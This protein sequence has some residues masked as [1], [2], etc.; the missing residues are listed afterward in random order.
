[1]QQTLLL[2]SFINLHP[3]SVLLLDEPDAHLE[4]LRQRQIY[5]LLREAATQNETQVICASHSEVIL[6]EAAQRDA[7]VAFVGKPHRVEDK[8]QVLKAL[9][10]IGF[11]DY[12]QAEITGFVLYLEGATDLALLRAFAR[13]LE[14]DAMEV[15]ER[16]FIKYVGN[17]I[18][19]ARTHFH[20]LREAKEDLL[21]YA[22]FDR[23][24]RD[25]LGTRRG[26]TEHMWP[27]R[28]IENYL[29]PPKTLPRFAKREGRASVS[30]TLFGEHPTTLFE[31][32]TSVRWSEAMNRA[33][34]D[35]VPRI[36]QRDPGNQFWINTRVSTDLLD[37]LFKSF[38]AELDLPVLMRKGGYHQLAAY[39]DPSDIHKDVIDVL[40]QIVILDDSASSQ[41]V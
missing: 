37:P 7:L 27:R 26:L 22:L 4:I 29:L 8:T 40:N 25:D 24:D 23:L 11:E 15:L 28:E 3:E 30:G 31:G 34:Q 2:L 6:N 39:L 10:D 1:M 20:G 14:H 36:A 12:Y 19:Q 38:F 32:A 18:S 41:N 33:I 17:H 21:G 13:V 9:R 5:E 16:P 35:Y